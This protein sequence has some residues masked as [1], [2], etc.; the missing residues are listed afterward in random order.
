MRFLFASLLAFF[1]INVLYLWAAAMELLFRMP[2]WL[3]HRLEL[4][5]L[6][7]SRRSGNAAKLA[8][9]R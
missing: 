9:K 8:R 2:P 3:Q 1:G 7:R 6:Y 5:H 4:A